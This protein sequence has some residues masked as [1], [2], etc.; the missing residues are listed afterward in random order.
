MMGI[1][2]AQRLCRTCDKLVL[3]QRQTPNHVLHL[4]LTLITAGLWLIVWLFLSIKGSPWR[5]PN[6]GSRTVAKPWFYKPKAPNK[7]LN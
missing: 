1:Q 4:L 6:C 5:C 3:A 7:I 2:T